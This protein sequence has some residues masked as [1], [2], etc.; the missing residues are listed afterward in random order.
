MFNQIIKG[1]QKV[2]NSLFSRRIKQLSVM[3]QLKN[4]ELAKKLNITPEMLSEY[5]HDVK[6]PTIN[7]IFKIKKVFPKLNLNWF[8]TETPE[9]MVE[10]KNIDI[11][12]RKGNYEPVFKQS[13]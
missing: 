8:C 6:T 11:F 3:F 9:D 7:L 12:D 1:V 2:T 13:E 5:Q 4:C 10:S